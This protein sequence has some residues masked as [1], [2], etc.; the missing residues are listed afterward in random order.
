MRL[1]SRYSYQP[2]SEYSRSSDGF[3]AACASEFAKPPRH[4]YRRTSDLFDTNRS[5]D[6]TPDL[7]LAGDEFPELLRC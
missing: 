2:G 4:G 5:D 7:D 3:G 1:A 6:I